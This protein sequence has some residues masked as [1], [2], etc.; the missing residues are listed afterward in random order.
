MGMSDRKKGRP[1]KV[2]QRIDPNSPITY[3]DRVV[4]ALDAGAFFEDACS[5][6]GVSRAA[7]YEW[8][9]RGRAAREEQEEHGEAHELSGNDRLYMD[10]SDAVERA[11]ASVVVTNLAI[12]RKAA[13]NGTWQAAAWY[14]ERTRP[15]QYG[16][17]QR[18]GE[19]DA[20]LTT[21]AAREKLLALDLGDAEIDEG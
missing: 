3:G 10:F 17:F 6:A 20:P 19:D 7:A 5:Y 21:D 11:R 12:I 13:Q 8:L 15:H 1:P 14:L 4:Q 9:A 18:P 2:A 16:R